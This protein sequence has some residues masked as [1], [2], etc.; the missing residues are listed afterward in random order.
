MNVL[1]A[2]GGVCVEKWTEMSHELETQCW[3]FYF[4]Q[5]KSGIFSQFFLFTTAA[6]FI[7]K[8]LATNDQKKGVSMGLSFTFFLFSPTPFLILLKKRLWYMLGF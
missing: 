7:Y 6:Y 8:N 2:L 5:G 1:Y 4:T 3:K